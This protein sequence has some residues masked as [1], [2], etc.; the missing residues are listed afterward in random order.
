[1]T[2]IKPVNLWTSKEHARDYL[3]RADSISHRGEGELALLEFIPR[4]AR[5]NL[6][7]RSGGQDLFVANLIGYPLARFARSK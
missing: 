6:D 1:M 4:G 7:L 5:H 2:A 3:E